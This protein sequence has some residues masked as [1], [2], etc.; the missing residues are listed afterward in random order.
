MEK[1]YGDGKDKR[2]DGIFAK[3]VKQVVMAWPR[4]S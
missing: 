4:P 1:K 2:N 3:G